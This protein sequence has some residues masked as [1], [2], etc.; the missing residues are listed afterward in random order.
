MQTG[1]PLRKPRQDEDGDEAHEFLV[2]DEDTPTWMER[3]EAIYWCTSSLKIL[4]TRRLCW[5]PDL[6]N[7]LMLSFLSHKID[8]PLLTLRS[9]GMPWRQ[10]TSSWMV[11]CQVGYQSKFW[12]I[13]PSILIIFICFF[14]FSQVCWN[15]QF[16]SIHFGQCMQHC[17]GVQETGELKVRGASGL[18]QENW[19]AVAAA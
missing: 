12:Q 1:V 19:S 8:P 17:C 3:T 5:Q 13:L 2:E 16:T 18:E 15:V 11:V 6:S 10:G 7:K 9:S 4:E 14:R